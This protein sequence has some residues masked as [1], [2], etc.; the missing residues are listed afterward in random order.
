VLRANDGSAFL[1]KFRQGT[2]PAMKDY[3]LTRFERLGV[4]PK[5]VQIHGWKHPVEH[6]K[7]YSQVDIALDTYPFNGGMTTLEG[8]WMGIPIISLV[9]KGSYLSRTGL[10][11]LSRMGLE[12]FATSTE[13]EYV[14]KATALARNLD[15]L[16]KIH[17]SMRRR[18]SASTICDADRFARE[19]ETAYREM[20][21]RWCRTHR[22]NTAAAKFT[23]DP[24]PNPAAESTAQNGIL[25]F[26]ISENSSLQFTVSKA[27]LPSFLLKAGNA[28]K[29][30]EVSEAA[31]LLN[32]QAVES[33]R[34]MANDDPGRADALFM[35]A[36]IF[37]KTGQVRKA[38]QFY[39]EVL[40]HRPHAL[41]LFELANICRDTGR[42]SEAVRYQEQAVELSPD[43]PELWTT[44][45]EY[46]IRM[47][48]TQRGIDLLRKAVERSPDKVNHSKFLWHLHQVPQL[49]RRALFE[50]HKRWARTHAPVSLTK[51]SHDN[52]P[53]PDRKLRVGYISPDFC[54][55][56]VAYFFESLLDGHD[57]EAVDL[58][59]YGN[60]A[61]PDPFT[62][63]L[64][65]KF[66][67]YRNVCGLKDEEVV[68][69]I[70]QDR[71]D[72]L[73]DLAGH[74]SGNR[75]CVLAHKPAPIQVTYLGFPDTTGMYQIDYRLTDELADT[76]EAQR[77][78]TEKLV[79]LPQGF[80]CYKPPGFAL[81]VTPLPAIERDCFT[82]GSFNNNCKIQPG[83]MELWAG[84]LK[85]KEKSRLLLKFS[86]GSDEAVRDHYFGQFE[87]L[88]IHRK[89]V[90]IC[91]RKPT[92]EHFKMYGQ[93][94][95]ALD[96]YPYNGTT[97]TCEAMW[98]G[99][100][101][102]SLVGKAHASRVGLSILSR[103]GLGDFAASTPSEYV[104]K[105]IAFSGE[106]ENLAKI[107]TSLRSMMFNSSLCDAK[108]FARN[109]EAAYRRMWRQWCRGQGIDAPAQEST[110]GAFHSAGSEA[111][112]SAASTQ[113]ES[114]PTEDD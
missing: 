11:I 24:D 49:D 43:S 51:A 34:Q 47:G 65:G 5:R 103:V 8:L 2:D 98:M 52:A 83:I 78:H 30:G 1:M 75:L 29:V 90:E 45:A 106:L 81:P 37:A 10:S 33:V 32:Y 85:S 7:L 60:V 61:C 40:R 13:K 79:F 67:H 73:V 111:L 114:G 41:V 20:W 76:P 101:T 54:A 93:V 95:I 82:F 77:F 87:K 97:T 6:M 109:I 46:L 50:E 35:L 113:A 23:S 55:H 62:E 68:R 71:I 53:E 102:I 105:A 86:G 4:D 108:G 112:C 91:G 70:E 92:V 74:T 69:M 58:Y 14:A 27:G 26:F 66:E 88:G 15:G 110:A 31:A 80:L 89:R 96:T 63:Q 16:E 107:R 36:A 42:L 28:V 25:E 3:Y 64:K 72:I 9:G 84:I 18:M 94:D 38:E 59:G 48:Q 19:M 44:L 104:A 17:T 12:F 56:S 22:A 100:P 21:H 39:K 99:V 57:R